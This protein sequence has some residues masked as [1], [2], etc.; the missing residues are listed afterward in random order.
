MSLKI[1]HLNKN[2]SNKLLNDNST[3]NNCFNK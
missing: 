3:G 2:L 1:K